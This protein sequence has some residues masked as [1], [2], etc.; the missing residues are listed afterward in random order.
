MASLSNVVNF[1]SET[2]GRDLNLGAFSG[3]TFK[4]PNK[5]NFKFDDISVDTTS[6]EVAANPTTKG[7]K[8][9]GG[10]KS[11]AG[12]KGAQAGLT[13]AKT[14]FEIQG[15]LQEYEATESKARF[16]IALANQQFRETIA[17]GKSAALREETKGF[18][19]GEQ[20]VLK[21][22]SQGQSASGGIASSAQLAEETLAVLNAS[23]IE[24]N[25]IRQA[26]GYKSKAN[27]IQH[28][29]NLAKIN[30]NNQVATSALSGAI[31]AASFF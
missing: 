3:D 10:P 2:E 29:L 1:E 16:N 21:A 17:L 30:R 9:L 28:D 13:V 19:R 26:Y 18:A 25:A 15:A 22:V 12:A 24:T 8:E 23:V 6:K 31:G 11:S 7:G 27:L 5:Q 20:A 4:D 14:F